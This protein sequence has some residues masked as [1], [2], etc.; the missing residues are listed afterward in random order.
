MPIRRI[1]HSD[2]A[3]AAPGQRPSV[4]VELIALGVPHGD[5]VVVEAVLTDDPDQGGAERFQAPRLSVHEWRVVWTGF[6][7]PPLTVMSRCSRFLSDFFSGTTWDQIRG[8]LPAGSTMQ[9]R[10]RPSSSSLTPTARQ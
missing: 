6:T 3:T 7:R 2:R 8:P 5:P 4:D 9:S 10:P 1:S